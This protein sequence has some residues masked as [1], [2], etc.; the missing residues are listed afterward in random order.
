MST[1]S[2][3]GNGTEQK[4]NTVCSVPERVP[5]SVTERSVF[6]KTL[7]PLTMADCIKTTEHVPFYVPFLFR[8]VPFCFSEHNG[9]RDV[10]FLKGENAACE[11]LITRKNTI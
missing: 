1:G 8:S 7:E 6:S 4:Q 3:K 11:L 5:F 2:R 10:P 9:T